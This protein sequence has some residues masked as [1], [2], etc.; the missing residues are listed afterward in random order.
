MQI[1]DAP[2]PARQ[3]LKAGGHWSNP[4]LVLGLVLLPATFLM[5]I[6]KQAMVVM[7]PLI[8]NSLGCSL[9]QITNIISAYS[10]TYALC[11]LPA[12]WVCRRLGAARTYALACL[13]WSL[14]LLSTAFAST[15]AELILCRALLGIG[16][17]PDWTAALITVQQRFR[18]IHR[19]SVIAILLAALS[20]GAVIG[21]PLSVFL[22]T[23]LS[24]RL[25]FAIYGTVGLLLFGI[26]LSYSRSVA[27][28]SATQNGTAL[29]EPFALSRLYTIG[30]AY[31]CLMGVEGFFLALFPLYLR[32][33]FHLN[34]SHVGWYVS[35]SY[36]VILLSKLL[37]GFASDMLLRAGLSQW[38]ARVP[39]GIAGLGG[40]TAF[41]A[42]ALLTSSSAAMLPLALIA[43]AF[44]GLG[45][46]SIWSCVQEFGGASTAR[47]S[48][49]TQFLGNLSI[50]VVPLAM[51]WSVTF[52]GN[53]W[54]A[55]GILVFLGVAGIVALAC[56]RGAVRA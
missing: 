15:I 51:S 46:V 19:S 11:Q 49:W 20:L 43:A 22:M 32:N 17:A 41:L 37:G 52:L 25:C 27:E 13:F 54:L 48:S 1:S 42:V 7:A 5:A 28:P 47:V 38:H 6:D 3:D 24:W 31:F 9:G 44:L 29:A 4:W 50:A 53:W 23:S 2:A 18:P 39:L 36:F 33:T 55:D 16:Q 45:Q 40:G 35:A 8:Q 30:S 12:G 56:V 26:L 34:M 21:A 14:A 10:F